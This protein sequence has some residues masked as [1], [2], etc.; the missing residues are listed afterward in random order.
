ME[1]IEKKQVLTDYLDIDLETGEILTPLKWDAEKQ[2]YIPTT[3]DQLSI[4]ELHI[5]QGS[6]RLRTWANENAKRKGYK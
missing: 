6:A 2:R 3:F 5:Y 4:W 1:T